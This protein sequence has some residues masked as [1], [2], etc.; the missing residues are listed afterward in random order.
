M[1]SSYLVHTVA[2]FKRINIVAISKQ[3]VVSDVKASV[4]IKIQLPRLCQ[5]LFFKNRIHYKKQT[6]QT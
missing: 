4:L 3:V 2:T 1:K 6:S 5:V